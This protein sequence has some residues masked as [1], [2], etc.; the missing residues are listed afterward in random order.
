MHGLCYTLD[1][2]YLEFFILIFLI[3]ISIHIYIYVYLASERSEIDTIRGNKLKSEI[4]FFKCDSLWE[5][6]PFEIKF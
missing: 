6:G 1:I 4:Y 3:Y 2:S 5:K